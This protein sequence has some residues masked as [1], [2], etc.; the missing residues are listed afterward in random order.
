M[1]I[2]PQI[3]QK[4]GGREYVILPYEEFVFLQESLEDYQDLR[5][6]RQ[7]KADAAHEPSRSLDDILCEIGE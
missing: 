1:S 3:I 2:H 5:M 6:L 4:E 7:E